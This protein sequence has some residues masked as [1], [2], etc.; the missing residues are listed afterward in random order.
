MTS[1]KT[2]IMKLLKKLKNKLLGIPN[3]EHKDDINNNS[4]VK[5]TNNYPPQYT[6]NKSYTTPFN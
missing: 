3:L 1:I 2:I 6:G 4:G 5:T